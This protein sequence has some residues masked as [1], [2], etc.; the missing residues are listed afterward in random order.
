MASLHEIE[1]I[2][3]ASAQK[4]Q[5]A[6]ITN[7]KQLFEQ[8]ATS[9]GRQKIADD[10]SISSKLILR[11]VNHLDLERIKGIGWE[12]ADLLEAAGVDTLPELAQRNAANLYAAL[13][14]TNAE[15]SLVRRLPTLSM[16]TGWID[17]AKT[18][19]RVITY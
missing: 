8:G 13:E 2:G 17:E 6:G 12:Y 1:G 18:L 5:A 14:K 7:V 4:L 19:P 10:T 16:V 11:W 15:K 9:K 3:E